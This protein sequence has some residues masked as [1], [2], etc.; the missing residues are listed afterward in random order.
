M[1][2]FI[3]DGQTIKRFIKPQENLNHAMWVTFRPAPSLDHSAV[4]KRYSDYIRRDRIQ[5]GEK[6]VFATIAERIIDWEIMDEDGNVIYPDIKPTKDTI[7]KTTPAL[8]DRL[9]L[10]VYG[11]RDGGDPPYPPYIRKDEDFDTTSSEVNQD[12]NLG[13]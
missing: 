6:L 10:I 11:Q 9:I 3:D 2:G 1:L 13:N 8:L 5:E 12:E 4:E 7:A